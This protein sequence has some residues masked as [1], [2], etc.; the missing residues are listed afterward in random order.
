MR[1]PI[2]N[3]AQYDSNEPRITACC[4]H[5]RTGL[6]QPWKLKWLLTIQYLEKKTIDYSHSHRSRR[7]DPCRSIP[8]N[9]CRIARS[10]NM[11]NFFKCNKTIRK[12]TLLKPKSYL[13]MK[14]SVFELLIFWKIL[15]VV[16][17]NF[18][19]DFLWLSWTWFI[20]AKHIS[21]KIKIRTKPN[22]FYPIQ[23]KGCLQWR[24]LSLADQNWCILKW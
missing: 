2:S 16:W 17:T 6:L 14:F 8:G 7:H 3:T 15:N 9:I 4:L 22:R 11:Y 24:C 19:A 12:L 23:M 10:S 21:W 1:S 20:T 13:I 18:L 5:K